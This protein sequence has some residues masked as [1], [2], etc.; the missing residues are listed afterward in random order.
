MLIK[1]SAKLILDAIDEQ[2]PEH[3]LKLIRFPRSRTSAKI[4]THYNPNTDIYKRATIHQLTQLY[5]QIPDDV[6]ALNKKDR[7]I[8]FKKK[9]F[10]LTYIKE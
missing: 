2:R 4:T 9:N 8:K 5:N 6:K 10:S 7:K 1:S 3:I